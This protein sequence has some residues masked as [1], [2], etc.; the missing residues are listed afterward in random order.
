MMMHPISSGACAPAFFSN[1]PHH[2]QWS[3]S[4]LQGKMRYFAMYTDKQWDG[5]PTC[6]F[7]CLG[8]ESGVISYPVYAYFPYF[9][10][11]K[12][13]LHP[14]WNWTVVTCDLN[15]IYKLSDSPSQYQFA[16][17]WVPS[18]HSSYFKR[19]SMHEERSTLES[20]AKKPGASIHTPLEP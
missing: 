2:Y 14:T 13:P 18:N 6:F 9:Q 7:C 5:L 16:R 19:E 1:L 3:L 10:D 15:D 11:Q 8:L 17:E 12:A 4:M 20:A